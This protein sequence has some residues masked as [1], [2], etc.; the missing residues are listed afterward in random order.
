MR[1]TILA[2]A[3]FA[4]LALSGCTGADETPVAAVTSS[5]APATSSPVPTTPA[6]P[7]AAQ[8][9]QPITNGGVTLT[10]TSA[11]SVPT[12]SMNQAMTDNNSPYA[13][14]ADV[15]PPPGAKYVA[16]TVHVTNN[17]Q[18]SMDLTC[19]YPIANK[20]VNAQQQQY[21][22]IEDLY[23]LK[24]NPLCNRNLQPGF[25]SDMTYVYAV[26]ADSQIVG[27]GFADATDINVQHDFSAVAFSA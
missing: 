9:G 2:T 16:V 15:P 20:L 23:K 11:V 22:T 24:G 25:A 10:V 18:T 27:W 5:T 26:P 14:F 12:I 8:V 17:S 7:P 6:P 1:R 13:K 4:A 21:D 19:G 3:A